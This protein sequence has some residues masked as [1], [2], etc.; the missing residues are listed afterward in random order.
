MQEYKNARMQE[1]KN[2]A[3]KGFTKLVICLLTPLRATAIH[4]RPARKW[5]KKS[6]LESIE[7]YKVS[8][9]YMSSSSRETA[10]AEAAAAGWGSKD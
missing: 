7:R 10:A 5:D 3:R 4:S 1:C 6:Q 8:K 9:Q 2:N